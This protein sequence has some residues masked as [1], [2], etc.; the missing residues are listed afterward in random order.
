MN[1]F[2]GAIVP[3][4]DFGNDDG[5]ASDTLRHAMADYVSNRSMHTFRTVRDLLYPSR[6][7]VPVVA[8]VDDLHEDTGAEKDSHMS[9]VSL[10]L[11]DGRTALLAFTGLDSL[12]MWNPDARP[13]PKKAMLVAQ[14]ALIENYDALIVDVA[15]PVPCF[16]DEVLLA[17]VALGD[18]RIAMKENRLNQVIDG[19]RNISE[20][21][22]AQWADVND[23]N[24]EQ[25][26]VISLSMSGAISEL[27]DIIPALLTESGVAVAIDT[28][29]RVE[30]V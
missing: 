15:G 19:L 12:A 24:G 17:Q 13:I 22:H 29:L 25:A 26:I 6:L 27:G 16:V 7:L 18:E 11:T 9:S 5:A 4:T 30:V 20:I 28:P 3:E 10:E 14:S 2:T 8:T 21:T 1:D 23:D